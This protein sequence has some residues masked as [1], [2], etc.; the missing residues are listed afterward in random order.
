MKNMW[1][2]AKRLIV[3]IICRKTIKGNILMKI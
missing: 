1:E 2:K 3:E